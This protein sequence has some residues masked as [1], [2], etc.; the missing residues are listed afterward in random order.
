MKRYPLILFGIIFFINAEAQ[1]YPPVPI[2]HDTISQWSARSEKIINLTPLKK[3]HSLKKWYLEKLKNGVVT[4]YAQ[5]EG[6]NYFS[7]YELSIPQLTTQDW[8][9]GLVVETSPM[10]TLQEWYFVDTTISGYEKYKYRGGVFNPVADT[11]CGCDDAD[12]FRT[13]QILNYRDGK[14]SINNII[15]SPLCARQTE[16]PPFDW[17]ALCNVAEY[18]AESRFP[19]ISKDA[20]LLNTNELTYHFDRKNPSPDDRI[21]TINKTDIGSL[22]Y[23]DILKGNLKAID[24]E[25][26]KVIPAKK[27]LSF[28]MSSDTTASFHEDPVRITVVHRERSSSDLNCIRIKQDFYFDFKNERLY[29]VVR[30]VTLMEIIYLPNGVVRGLRSFCRLE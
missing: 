8:L 3:E 30:S 18:H 5:K 1:V 15:V 13:K 11:C 6:R 26:G 10:K 14:F 19:V 23:Q 9:K 12:A 4:A 25:S 7:P 21:L 16:K 22:I 20:I 28:G 27:L 29:S 24:V 17:H 2:V